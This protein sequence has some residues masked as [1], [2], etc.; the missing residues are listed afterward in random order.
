MYLFFVPQTNVVGLAWYMH[1][2]VGLP[3]R[4]LDLLKRWREGD[5]AEIDWWNRFRDD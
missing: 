2:L 1:D 5:G 3:D 4:E